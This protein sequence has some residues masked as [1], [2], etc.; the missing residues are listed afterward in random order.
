[1]GELAV[2][3][4]VL[5]EGKP[6]KI[7]T[8]RTPNE[9]LELHSNL[10]IVSVDDGGASQ[11]AA[12][13]TLHSSVRGNEIQ[14]TLGGERIVETA[15]GLFAANEV[16]V[17]D[18]TETATDERDQEESFGER[19]IREAGRSTRLNRA[20]PRLSEADD[21][22]VVLRQ[23]LAS[24]SSKPLPAPRTSSDVKRH[25]SLLWIRAQNRSWHMFENICQLLS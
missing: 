4:D 22:C 12:S 20:I 9:Y 14:L 2:N 13:S 7:E 17:E 5:A 21:H 11:N 19:K 23:R 1:M 8:T 25:C 24:A 16:E 3:A 15:D 6:E 10:N 18:K